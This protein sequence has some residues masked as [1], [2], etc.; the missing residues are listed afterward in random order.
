MSTSEGNRL[1]FNLK[2]RGKSLKNTVMSGHGMPCPY[3]RLL[4]SIKPKTFA[5]HKK[6]RMLTKHAAFFIYAF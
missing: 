6:G 2:F 4:P 3:T 1:D 5:G